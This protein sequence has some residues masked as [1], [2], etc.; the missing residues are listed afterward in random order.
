LIP[1]NL[2]RLASDH[3]ATAADLQ[4]DQQELEN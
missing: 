3:S 4:T 2:T 1:K